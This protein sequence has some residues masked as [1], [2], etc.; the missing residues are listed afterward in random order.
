MQHIG[1]WVHL[2][3]IMMSILLSYVVTV[4]QNYYFNHMILKF[5]MILISSNL[6]K[7]NLN[8]FCTWI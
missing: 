5:N 8:N 6:N 2:V 7:M 1:P 3:V 4:L